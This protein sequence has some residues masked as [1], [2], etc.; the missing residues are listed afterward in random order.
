MLH[1]LGRGHLVSS[2]VDF[3][4]YAFERLAT[5]LLVDESPSFS[6]P[7]CPVPIYRVLSLSAVVNRATPISVTGIFCHGSLKDVYSRYFVASY[8]YI[9]TIARTWMF[10]ITNAH[11]A[12]VA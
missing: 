8:V 6:V 7:L 1:C 4:G 9:N 2:V 11:C 5:L 10:L 3:F 12:K